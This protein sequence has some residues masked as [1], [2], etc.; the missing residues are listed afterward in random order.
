MTTQS[1]SPI[2]NHENVNASAFRPVVLAVGAILIAF[3]VFW[4][5]LIE[6]AHRWQA[7]EEY[8]HGFLIPVVTVWLLW[9]RREALIASI[10]RPSWLGPGLIILALA[11]H[12][13]GILSAIFILSQ[14]GFIICLIGIV[15]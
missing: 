12:T 4:P 1:L 8:S 6:L 15:L 9:Q 10:D 14:V 7:Q 5:A 13:L 11:M 3:A 2:R